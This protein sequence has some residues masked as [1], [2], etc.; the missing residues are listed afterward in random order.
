MDIPHLFIH[1]HS[2]GRG[3]GFHHLAVVNSA[4]MNIQVHVFVGVPVFNSRILDPM[5]TLRLAF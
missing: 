3:G 4:A 5:I 2:E 1:S